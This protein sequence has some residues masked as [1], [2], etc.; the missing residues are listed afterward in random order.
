MKETKQSVGTALSS[1]WNVEMQEDGSVLFLD[2][3]GEHKDAV[4]RKEAIQ[5]QTKQTPS[6]SVVPLKKTGT[7]VALFR[8]CLL[9]IFALPSVPPASSPAIIRRGMVVFTTVGTGMSGFHPHKS[10]E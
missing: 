6:S 8:M 5:C 10:D 9:L 2:L 4:C 7:L 1:L 3:R